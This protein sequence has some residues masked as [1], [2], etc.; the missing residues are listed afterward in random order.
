[1]NSLFKIILGLALLPALAAAK[2]PDEADLVAMR[3]LGDQ[4]ASWIH[5]IEPRPES[6]AIFAINANAPLD[7]DSARI[8]ETEVRKGLSDR[9]LN[10]VSTCYECRNP[11]VTVKDDKVIV[12]AGVA[13]A[14]TLKKV[15]GKNP[16][17]A[18]LVVDLYRTKL[19]MNAQAQL[20][21]S[22]TGDMLGVENFSVPALSFNDSSAQ[23]LFTFGIG[24]VLPRNGS[25]EV[26]P[27][28]NA[29]LLEEVGF[30]KAGLTTGAIISSAHG[31]LIYVDPT[32]AFRGR[33]GN[34]G[35][36]WSLLLGAGYGFVGS[37][38]GLDLRGSFEMFFGSWAV[39]GFEYNYLL[40]PGGGTVA[41]PSYAG[42]HVGISFG[43]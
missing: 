29:S 7:A 22:E 18:F 13:D 42:F 15:S 6:L 35:M 8:F 16:A 27:A 3:Y 39:L 12:S 31:N 5:K 14:E 37:D 38:R 32:V 19:R 25:T 17:Q 28:V 36:T 24:F 23:L 26:T 2:T 20:L 4:M 1:V 41:I 9:G 10:K 11:F 40:N 34:S 30:A 33:F 43:R 21:N